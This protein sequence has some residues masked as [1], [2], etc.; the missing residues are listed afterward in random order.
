MSVPLKRRATIF[1]AA[2]VLLLQAA[3]ESVAQQLERLRYNNPGL[4]VDLG[5]GLWGIPFPVDYD[6]DG[7]QDLLVGSGGKPYNGIF[8]FEGVGEE[9]G[10]MVFR[11]GVWLS[12]AKTNMQVSYL[13]DGW[14]ITGPGIAYPDFK[15]TFLND[16][17][18]IPF[19][20]KF[21][22]GRS[23]QW[24]YFDYNGDG[25]LDLIIGVSDW[26][27]YGWD[28]A[29]NEQGEW[30][31][32]PLRANVHWMENLGTNEEPD[33]AEAKMVMVGDQPIEV[34]GMP[35][36]SFADFNGDGLPDI[37]CGEFLDRLTFFENIGTRT[38]P[39]YAPG[40]FLKSEGEVIR[41][42][43][44]MIQPVAI[45]WDGDGH[46]DLVVGE[47]D[48]RVA[49][50]KNTG[51]LANGI[52]EFS[53]PMHFRQ[54]ADDV[55]I[56]ALATPFAA[57]W[58]GDGKIDL[59][60]G[61]TAGY[62]AFLENL[63]GYPPRWAEPKNLE[64][65]GEVIR[66]LAGENGSIQGPAEAKWGY[67]VLSVADWNSD[68]LPDIIVNSIWGKVVWYENTGTRTEPKL[69]GAKPIEVEWEGETP[70]PA[71]HWWDP[72]GKELVTQWR[73]SV[74]AIDLTGNGLQ[75][76]VALDPDGFLAFYERREVDGQLK[77]LPPRRIFRVE[78]NAP[79]VFDH[80]HRA[81]EIAREDGSNDLAGLDEE[82]RLAFFGHVTMNGKREYGIV[83]RVPPHAPAVEESGRGHPLRMTGGWAGR[84]G[85][86]KFILTDWTGDG[87][88]DLLVNSEN[89]TLLENI[90]DKPGQFL[91]R[92]RGKVDDVILAG[93][94]TSPAVVDWNEDGIPDLVV[95]GE[96][97]FLYTM[98]NPRT[99]TK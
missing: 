91:F 60:S 86:R 58:N 35:S 68:G 80:N 71:W 47:E 84:S 50:V 2:S 90:S 39:R 85:R 42:D 27:E 99:K 21:H 97:G 92:D 59:I 37:V 29:Y 87:K 16:G 79:S 18:K 26:R 57:D 64:A 11:P 49:L 33:Y 38:E 41:M 34:Y 94:T 89:V 96:D 52:P 1:A 62:V 44:Q 6:G 15:E 45:D 17:Q 13:E 10:P 82:G 83:K 93:H 8:R 12:P 65:D 69:A 77:L 48:G 30:V 55:K 40:R 61:N 9:R 25:V 76:L 36:P 43:L 75:D 63:G 56:G 19:K 7:R 32:G 23:N 53:A 24:R 67:T 66:I 78:E 31:N 20:P 4:E 22:T 81:V 46:V 51:H 73:S 28:D 54:Q 70:K 72:E 3:P 74:Q 98:E 95:G 14:V 88:L 5:V